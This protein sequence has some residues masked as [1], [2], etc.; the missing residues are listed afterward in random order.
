LK[1]GHG[2]NNLA[3]SIRR[4]VLR[5]VFALPAFGTIGVVKAIDGSSA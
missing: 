1:F 4:G 5:K 2:E 3:V